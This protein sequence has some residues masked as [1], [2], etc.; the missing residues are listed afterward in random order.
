MDFGFKSIKQFS[1]C[2]L[3]MACSSTGMIAHATAILEK[4]GPTKSNYLPN[5]VTVD[6]SEGWTDTTQSQTF[7]LT[8]SVQNA[9]IAPAKQKNVVGG[10][11]FL[12]WQHQLHERIQGQWGVVG[13]LTNHI[14]LNGNVLHAAYAGYDYWTYAYNISHANVGLKGKLIADTPQLKVQPYLSASVGVGFNRSYDF[15][16]TP[17]LIQVIAAPNFASNTET[18]F[19]YTVGIGLQKTINLHWAVGLGYEFSDWGNSELARAPGQT[20]NS[21]LQQPHTYVNAAQLNVTYV[22]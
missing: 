19:T 2:S 20:V 3:L 10:D 9:Y 11:I 8:P 4:D 1:Y 16:N 15:S 12:G 7:Y 5:I 18:A 14:R 6:F 17:K 21:G 13:G 22:I